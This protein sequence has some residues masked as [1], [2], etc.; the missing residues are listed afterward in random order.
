MKKKIIAGLLAGLLI[1]TGCGNKPAE[2]KKNEV[3]EKTTTTETQQKDTPIDANADEGAAQFVLSVES[4]FDDGSF[5]VT[6]SKSDRL[7]TLRLMDEGM[8]A[9]FNFAKL[10]DPTYIENTRRFLDSILVLSQSLYSMAPGYGLIM[11]D[12]KGDPIYAAFNG[13]EISNKILD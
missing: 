11:T 2:T 4:G 7:V 10:G 6:A 9:A 8:Q 5:E 13:V 1:S 12:T 3:L